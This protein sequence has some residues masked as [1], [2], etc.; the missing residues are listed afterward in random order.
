V[1]NAKALRYLE[2]G[3]DNPVDGREVHMPEKLRLL[4]QGHH[5][6]GFDGSDN[7]RHLGPQ[8][9]TDGP[10]NVSRYYYYKYTSGGRYE[11]NYTRV[12]V[13]LCVSLLQYIMHVYLKR[14]GDDDGGDY[15]RKWAA[16]EIFAITA[17]APVAAFR[18]NRNVFG[19]LFKVQLKYNSHS[20][21]NPPS[22]LGCLTMRHSLPGRSLPFKEKSCFSLVNAHFHATFRN[23]SYSD[24]Q[25]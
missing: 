19:S 18:I 21:A 4:P 7:I 11:M 6:F 13:C 17:D 23:N 8:K 12:G 16:S 14:G 10:H 1:S 25:S 2:G 15:Y 5:S 22:P 9:Q 3:E 24:F 20:A